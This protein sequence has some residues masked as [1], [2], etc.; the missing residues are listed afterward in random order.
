MKSRPRSWPISAASP[1]EQIETRAPS[2]CHRL[3]RRGLRVRR[4][5][6]ARRAR[7][8]GR[9]GPRCWPGTCRWNAAI[10]IHLYVAAE[11]AGRRDPVA[12]V[13][14]A[15]RR[16]R[17]SGDRRANVALIGLLAHAPAGA[18]PVALSRTIG[19]G[20]DMGRPSILQGVG[21]E[22]GRH[23]DRDLYRR[24]LRADDEGHDRPH[25][26]PSPDLVIWN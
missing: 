24:A 21:R 8:G 2:P 6:V 13:R 23:G 10:G 18:G 4:G 11:G 26:T 7:P 25:L 14:A 16:P 9:R 5:D 19:Q 1:A 15:V 12:H 3:V 20:F 22:E 17:G